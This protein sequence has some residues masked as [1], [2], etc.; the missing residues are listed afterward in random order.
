MI[1]IYVYLGLYI[2]LLLAVSWFVSRRQSDEDFLISG[3]NRGGWQILSSK[4]ATFVGA[5]VFITYTGL[6][7]EYGLGVFAMLAGILLGYSLF[8]YWAAPKIYAESRRKKFYTMGD[9]VYNRTRSLFALKLSNILANIILF[10]WLLVG[11][12]GGAK[13][14][15]DFG[16]LSYSV[17]VI[18]TSIVVLSY[19]YLAG[20]KAVL[21]TD[22]VQS[23]IIL[24]LLFLITF[25]VIGSGDVFGL[26]SVETG[27]IDIGTAIAFFLF[28][29]LSIFSMSNIFQL[30]YAAKNEKELKHGIGLA[31]V[32]VLITVSFLLIIGLFMASQVKGLDAGLVFSEALRNFLPSS[33]LPLA[34]VLFFAGIMSSAD[35][36]VYAIASH[37]VM[38]RRD[39]VSPVKSIR[40]VSIVLMMT[41][42]VISLIF[43]DIVD[44]S[45]VTGGL[46]LTLSVPILYLL[47]GGKNSGSFVGSVF[48]GLSGLVG[49]MI[50]LGIEPVAAAVILIGALLGLLFDF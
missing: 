35:T 48:G 37:F 2:L 8:G 40:L 27:S 3:R 36:N 10:F 9:F 32:P 7:Y 18:L 42:T 4:F 13:I 17:A 47:F 45:I 24:L 44:V 22:I 38:R 16:M 15:S 1:D 21:L 28:G 20:L 26:L 5:A 43:T 19:V 29:L 50:V 39:V 14:I 25:S 23:F 11:I 6:A 33:L 12:I 34:I 49:G 41:V 46:S 31:I 30:C